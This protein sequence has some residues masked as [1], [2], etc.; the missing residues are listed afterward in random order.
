MT[1][2]KTRKL[3]C[4]NDFRTTAFRTLS[5]LAAPVMYLYYKLHEGSKKETDSVRKP[6]TEK[7]IEHLN[8][9][10]VSTGL[11]IVGLIII[12]YNQIRNLVILS[13]SRKNTCFDRA[14]P[15]KAKQISH[16]QR[17][18]ERGSRTFPRKDNS[19]EKKPR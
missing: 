1:H 13:H 10:I 14:F 8:K 3:E 18:T 17:M 7:E 19:R 15:G 5:V 11:L 6:T 2:S 9:R 4:G 16:F 12:C